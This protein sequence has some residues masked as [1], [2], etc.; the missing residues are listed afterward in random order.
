MLIRI[1]ILSWVVGPLF[2]LRGLTAKELLHTCDSCKKHS[3]EAIF[4][5]HVLSVIPGNNI[6]S[7]QCWPVNITCDRIDKMTKRLKQDNI[8][9]CRDLSLAAFL[10][11]AGG[12]KP[13]KIINFPFFLRNVFVVQ[14]AWA[15]MGPLLIYYLDIF[16]KYWNGLGFF[17]EI[18]V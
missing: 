1:R 12:P 10:S 8:S 18:K 16:T 4:I 11:I 2:T 14:L 5:Y 15:S 13:K 3:N 9:P 7:F 17:C 6:K